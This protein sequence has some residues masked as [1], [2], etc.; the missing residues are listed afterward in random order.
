MR[1]TKSCGRALCTFMAVI[2]LSACASTDSMDED[3]KEQTTRDPNQIHPVVFKQFTD[4]VAEE[5]KTQINE[6][7]LVTDSEN[8]FVIVFE[9]FIN[10]TETIPLNDFE[11]FTKRL[12]TDLDDPFSKNKVTF[13][14]KMPTSVQIKD[15]TIYSLNCELSRTRYVKTN[16]YFLKYQ[17]VDPQTKETVFTGQTINQKINTR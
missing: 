10:K 9:Q 1:R 13:A 8:S 17:L 4:E 12:R 5:L 11:Y 15:T 6:A 14:D 3:P 2:T 16:L 7:P